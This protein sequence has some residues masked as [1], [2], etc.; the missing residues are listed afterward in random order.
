MK[1]EYDM[2]YIDS[3]LRDLLID[4]DDDVAGIM[5]EWSVDDEGRRTLGE[6]LADYFND[7][8]EF[9]PPQSL[10]G[11]RQTIDILRKVFPRERSDFLSDLIENF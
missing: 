2:D 7:T 10:V 9:D 8:Y 11:F 3:V 5:D 1:T 4:I 6:T